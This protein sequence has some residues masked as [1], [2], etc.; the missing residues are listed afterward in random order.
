VE[1]L[2]VRSEINCDGV[3]PPNGEGSDV[4]SARPVDD[5]REGMQGFEVGDELDSFIGGDAPLGK[6]APDSSEF[7][8]V[9]ENRL[10]PRRCGCLVQSGCRVFCPVRLLSPG[11]VHRLI[12]E[13]VGLCHVFKALLIQDKIRAEGVQQHEQVMAVKLDRGRGQKDGGFG[14]F[15]EKPDRLMRV[16]VLIADMVGFI[17]D[18][19]V[20]ARGRVQVQQT[21]SRLF[22]AFG[23]RTVKKR[24][25]KQRIREDCFPVLVGPLPFQVH[26]ID[27]VSQSAAVQM[28]EPLV[29]ASHLKLPLA[30][31]HQWAGAYDEDG[32]DL[33]PSL[34]FPQNQA[35]FDSLAD[36]HTIGDQQSRA[37]RTDESE[38]WTELVGN[39]INTSRVE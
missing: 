18:H 22:L 11:M 16:G 2:L 30:L 35:G 14:V 23:T 29:K 39:E 32:L 26:F 34:Q 4:A 9:L 17:H 13:R 7:G 21:F 8:I 27:A 15:T 28:G 1:L 33:P 5:S 36:A 19:E 3:R 24:F 10:P 37:V 25:V 38:H 31:S 6:V 12:D 20:E